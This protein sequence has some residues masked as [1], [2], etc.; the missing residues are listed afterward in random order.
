[1]EVGYTQVFLHNPSYDDVCTGT[2]KHSEVVR[3]QY[4]P[5]KCNFESLLDLFWSRHNPTMLNHQVDIEDEDN[6]V[7]KMATMMSVTLKLLIAA[8]S[9]Q[10]L[11][12]RIGKIEKR[13]QKLGLGM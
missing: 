1:M 12:N 3:V 5:K 10:L 8:A 11:S 6:N 13:N 9:F 4:D 7:E 2:T